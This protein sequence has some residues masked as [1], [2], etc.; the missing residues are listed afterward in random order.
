MGDHTM[1]VTNEDLQRQIS[2][3]RG[4]FNQ[5]NASLKELI[6]LGTAQQLQGQALG[7]LQKQFGE[8]LSRSSA[9]DV[10]QW[11]L[12]NETKEKLAS[13]RSKI[14]GGLLVLSFFQLALIGTIGWTV[15]TV[16]S[17]NTMIAVHERRLNDQGETLL[18]LRHLTGN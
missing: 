6:E 7:E 5:I 16:I 18:A 12:I 9:N 10:S 14:A 2:D 8:Y 17:D 15:Q 4:T 13:L 11:A 3:M 1:T